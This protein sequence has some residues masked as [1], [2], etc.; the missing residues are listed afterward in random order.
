MDAEGSRIKLQLREL[1][2]DCLSNTRMTVANLANIVD[3]IQIGLVV[4]IIEI[5][6]TTIQDFQWEHRGVMETERRGNEL[7]SQLDNFILRQY[8]M[9][10]E[11]RRHLSHS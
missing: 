4:F 10:N 5:L 6:A 7:L 2:G 9:M 11:R 8:L 1:R 3:A